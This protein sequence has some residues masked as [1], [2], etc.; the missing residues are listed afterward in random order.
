LSQSWRQP[1]AIANTHLGLRRLTTE[2]RVIRW[3]VPATGLYLVLGGATSF[4]GWVFDVPA[5]TDWV[6][7]G[8]SIQPNATLCVIF[9]GLA[10]LGLAAGRTAV[11]RSAGTLVL[12][13]GGATFLQW[14]TGFSFGID[15]ILL[16]SREWGR[17]GV[18]FPGRMGPPG[19][20]AWTLIG[21]ALVLTTLDSPTRRLAPT[22][23][24]ITT[25][26]SFLSLIGYFYR[27]D[28][29]FSHP[30]LTVIALQTSTFVLAASIG[31][32]ACHPE[33]EPALTLMDRGSAG[34]L[35]RRALPVVLL[36][37]AVLGYLR[38][39]GQN[40][41]LY[42]TTMG[43]ALFVLV[44]IWLLALLVWWALRAVRHAAER[45]ERELDEASR[46]RDEF[47]ATLAH[48]LRNPLAPVGNAVHVL[49]V[50]G[51]SALPWAQEIVERQV[52]HMARLIDDLMDVSR[53]NQGKLALRREPVDISQVIHTAVE[54][55]RPLLNERSQE[56]SVSLPDRPVRLDADFTRL[57]QV[58][59]NLLNNASK[60][61]EQGG[62]IALGVST[63][64]GEAVVTV[65]D[66]GIGIPEDTQH[67]V[68]DL[69]FQVDRSVE[70][71]RG[72]LGVGL[73]LVKRIVELHGGRVEVQ[74][75]GIG[76]GCTFKVWMPMLRDEPTL[77]AESTPPSPPSTAVSH[78]VLVVDDNRDAADSLASMLRMTGHDVR[79]SYDGADAVRVGSEYCPA[80]V[81][82][83]IG[84]PG[85]DGNDAARAIRATTWGQAAVLVALTGWGQEADRA[86]TTASGFD[87]HFVKPVRP[88]VILGLVSAVAAER[89]F[90]PR[91]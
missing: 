60:Y 90:T 64:G 58:F 1:E 8:I 22:F 63:E 23:C 86:R 37:P 83:D 66:D 18:V 2:V 42:D 28:P 39:A 7:D 69:F 67:K 53:I 5:L 4:A 3:I 91:V 17:V 48:E 13:I 51:A 87:H 36:L 52:R 41:G 59:A 75:D 56:L 10:L 88:D 25:A 74:S 38:L 70:R 68:F 89:R 9:S 78:R 72:G 76:K 19:S 14:T 44:F 49:R 30:Y 33:S 35:A 82:L 6:G 81:F 40:A 20:L 62:H 21:T 77:A 84:M 26:L 61:S 65:R 29:L 16:F 45:R 27:A 12:L 46:N 80:V 11:D 71:A 47:L 73:A 57:A 24:L 55:N 43:V 15:D 79:T 31:I 34:E 32:L 50:R 54:T 85:M